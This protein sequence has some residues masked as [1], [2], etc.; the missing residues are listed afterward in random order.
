[1]TQERKT[2]AEGM[3]A[4]RPTIWQRLGFGACAVPNM[5]DLEDSGLAPAHLSTN[6]TAVFDWRD[7]LRILVSGKVMVETAVKTDVIVKVMI[8]RSSV[9]VLPPDWPVSPQEPPACGRAA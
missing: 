7:R 9:S 2:S 1:M 5:D 8:C 4:R 3:T 6:T